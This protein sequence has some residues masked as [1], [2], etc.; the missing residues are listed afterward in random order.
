MRTVSV[1]FTDEEEAKFNQLKMPFTELAR[2]A[3]N[4]Y[5]PDINRTIM[6]GRLTRQALNTP[7]NTVLTDIIGRAIVEECK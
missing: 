2:W 5:S 6:V 1:R 3:V 7:A 4:T